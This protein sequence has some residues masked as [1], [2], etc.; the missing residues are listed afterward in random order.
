LVSGDLFFSKTTT[1]REEKIIQE[2]LQTHFNSNKSE[3]KARL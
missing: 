2:K 3:G 1:K